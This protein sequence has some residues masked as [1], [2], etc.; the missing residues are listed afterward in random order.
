MNEKHIE[1]I[2]TALY[3]MIQDARAMP[4]GPDK[5]IIER[6]KALD[7]L[8]EIIAQLPAELKQSRTIVESRNE[9]IGQARREAE[10]IIRKAQEQADMLVSQQA[11]YNEAKRQCVEMVEQTK[12]QIAGLRKASNEYMDNALARTEEAIAQSLAEVKDTR[13]KFQALTAQPAPEAEE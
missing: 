10:N 3:D 13:A 12:T 7:M 5:C 11:I 9:L 8:D 4:L 6:D 1:D 2:I